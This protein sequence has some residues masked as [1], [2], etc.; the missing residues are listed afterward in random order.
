MRCEQLVNWHGSMVCSC[1]ICHDCF[2]ESNHEGHEVTC[3][4]TRGMGGTCDC[5]DAEAW[6]GA[7]R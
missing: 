5:G 3:Y 2:E 7:W 6:A 1:V 4:Q